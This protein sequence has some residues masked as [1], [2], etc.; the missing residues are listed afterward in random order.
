MCKDNVPGRNW[1]NG[2]MK[3]I[4]LTKRV[5]SNIKTSTVAINESLTQEFRLVGSN[6]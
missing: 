5:S 6:S 3:Q 1:V 2:I 4:N